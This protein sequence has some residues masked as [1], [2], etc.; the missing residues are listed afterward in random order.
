MLVGPHSPIGN[1]SLV[2][3]AETQ[4]DDVLW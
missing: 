1:Q 3:I 2:I 4:A